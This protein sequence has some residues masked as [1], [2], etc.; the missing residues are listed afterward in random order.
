[1]CVTL[2]VVRAARCSCVSGLSKQCTLNT[3]C[4]LYVNYTSV[5]LCK[6]GNIKIKEKKDV[7]GTTFLFHTFY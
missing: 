3:G 6:K 1:M 2:I 5:N 7:S 4:S